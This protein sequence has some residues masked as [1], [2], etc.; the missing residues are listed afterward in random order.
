M[1]PKVNKCCAASFVLGLTFFD[2]RCTF[3]RCIPPLND[4]WPH[5]WQCWFKI[6]SV[7]VV[8]VPRQRYVD[9][10]TFYSAHFNPSRLG[11]MN[12]CLPVCKCF[13]NA[14]VQFS[15]AFSSNFVFFFSWCSRDLE[16]LTKQF[17]QMDHEHVLGNCTVQNVL[18]LKRERANTSFCIC[19]L[20]KENA[21]YFNIISTRGVCL[22][23]FFQ[24][25]FFFCFK[26]HSGWNAFFFLVRL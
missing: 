13:P 25:L 5:L 3:L 24:S 22:C 8:C 18:K 21:K 20:Q 23:A 12:S 1:L 16:T 11:W 19:I 17:L 6:R 14:L 15:F 2:L 26:N 7:C 10:C 9:H 4:S